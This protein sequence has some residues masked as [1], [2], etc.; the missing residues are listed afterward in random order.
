MS[1]RWLSA[2]PKE[3]RL[4]SPTFAPVARRMTTRHRLLLA[5]LVLG[6]IVYTLTSTSSIADRERQLRAT[7]ATA[8][9]TTT[10]TTEAE[11]E[12][13][14]ESPD[15]RQIPLADHKSKVKSLVSSLERDA[16]LE[17]ALQKILTLMPSEVAM[18]AFLST[19]P[20][21]GP[22]RLR[23]LGLRTRAFKTYFEAWEDLHL[24]FIG[25]KVHVRDDIIQYVRQHPEAL[26]TFQS[27][28]P[29]V[30]HAYEAY[31]TFIQ[32][33]SEMLFPWTSP[34]FADHMTLHTHF[35]NGG[36]GIVLSGGDGQA[37]FILTLIATFRELGCTLP[38]EVHY[39]GDNDLGEEWR[40]KMEAMGGVLTRDIRAMVRDEGWQLAGWAGK[41]F[42]LL[43]SSFREAMFIDADALFM[44]D[45][46]E[47]FDD[48]QY[49]E[50]GALFF[51]DRIIMPEL[52]KKWLQ[53]ILPAP[54]S[55]NVKESRFWT[56]ASGHQ[57]ESG[58]VLVD[59][60]KHFVALMMVTR[61]NGPDRDGNS[62]EG[63]VGIYD[64]VYG[65]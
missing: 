23:E 12:A 33:F 63:R 4:S 43:L 9:T 59:K 42:T 38:I 16:H 48:P 36:R 52:K 25:D 39:L 27:D 7:T 44:R 32:K 53:K 5:L 58:V 46:E 6:L 18:R 45:P 30:V 31:R 20:G 14:P 24:T 56:G 28:M 1:A 37:P 57:Q 40:E 65:M 47:L 13:K 34:Y 62:G 55:K 8:A 11:G 61:M 41:P 29:S 60:W 17:V 22:E 50:T 64:M 15:H 35:Y 26:D 19:I 51:K 2:P 49:L 21:T 54:V 3:G 10:T